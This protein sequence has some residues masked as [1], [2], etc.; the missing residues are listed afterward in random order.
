[1]LMQE[2]WIHGLDWDERLPQELSKKVTKWF[3]E[4]SM[5]SGIRI[6][7]C[8]QVREMKSATLH[9]LDASREAYSAVVY[10]RVKY[11]DGSLTVWLVAS[12]TKVAPLQSISIPLLELMGALL[13]IRLVKSVVNALSL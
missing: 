1:M 6:P 7:R 5:L 12:K 9:A 4:L 2:V 8:L 10:I 11:C 3:T 13:D